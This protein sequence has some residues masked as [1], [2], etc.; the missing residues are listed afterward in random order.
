MPAFLIARYQRWLARFILVAIVFQFL[1]GK[2]DTTALI[3]VQ[4]NNLD[5]LSLIQVIAHILYPLF[6]DL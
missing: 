5:F 4:H 1:N 2:L 3:H 6:S